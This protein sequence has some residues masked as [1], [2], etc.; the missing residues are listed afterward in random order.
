MS[1]TKLSVAT[2]TKTGRIILALN[3]IQA[4][5]AFGFA[6]DLWLEFPD[7]S[8][9]L[10]LD[11][12]DFAHLGSEGFLLGMTLLGF[13]LARFA[14]RV[15]HKDRSALD[16][17]LTSL[18]GEFDSVLQ[19]HFERWNLTPAQRDVALLTLRGLRLSD[20]A[21]HRGSAEGT[22]KAHLSAVFRAA[23]VRTRSELVGLFMEEF[24]DFG[25]IS[26]AQRTT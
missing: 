15:L 4:L 11:H 26:H 1:N 7:P 22:V 8:F 19:E 2:L 14:M 12:H 21:H 16:S 25:A 6:A 3:L 20:I 10:S 9:W 23:N 24:L 17:K 18:K 5:C 13:A